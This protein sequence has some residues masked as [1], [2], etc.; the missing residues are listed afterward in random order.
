MEKKKN[1]L[2]LS[3]KPTPLAVVS[4][5]GDEKS[6]FSFFRPILV[7][8]RRINSLYPNATYSTKVTLVVV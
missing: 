3:L 8:R 5:A 1:L 2:I 7:L 4:V 6:F